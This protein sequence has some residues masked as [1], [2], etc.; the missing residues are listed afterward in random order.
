MQSILYVFRHGNST[1]DGQEVVRK[2]SLNSDRGVDMKKSRLQISEVPSTRRLLAFY[3]LC[4][5][6]A[7]GLTDDQLGLDSNS[8]FGL[9]TVD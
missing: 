1:S 3:L 5:R 4:R 8:H 2:D 6:G 9:L 7:G